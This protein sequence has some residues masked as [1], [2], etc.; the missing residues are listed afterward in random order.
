LGEILKFRCLMP[1]DLAIDSGY[2][3][4]KLSGLF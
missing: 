3:F 2:L 1:R 4:I